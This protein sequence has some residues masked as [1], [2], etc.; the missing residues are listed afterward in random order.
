MAAL[1][2]NTYYNCETCEAADK[3]GRGCRHGLLFPL[4]LIMTKA[5]DCPNYKFKYKE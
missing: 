4:L 2:I 3:Y 1:N 5:N